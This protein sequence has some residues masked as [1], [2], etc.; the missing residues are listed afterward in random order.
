MKNKSLERHF[1]GREGDCSS[2]ENAPLLI[3]QNRLVN[4]LDIMQIPHFIPLHYG[5]EN[6]VALNRKDY[7]SSLLGEN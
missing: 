5:S 4:F 3:H 2:L 6:D 7:T 1:N